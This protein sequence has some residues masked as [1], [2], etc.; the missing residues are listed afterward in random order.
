MASFRDLHAPDK[1]E[2]A[3]FASLHL[4]DGII[5]FCVKQY[6]LGKL[7]KLPSYLQGKHINDWDV[8]KVTNMSRLFEGLPK[9]NEPLFK[10]DVGLVTNMSSM[11]CDC[12]LFNQDLNAWGS[13]VGSVTNMKS[14]FQHCSH[15][16]MPL[17]KWDVSRV[18]TME[19][20]FDSC[21]LFNQ[22]LNAW[23]VGRVQNMISLFSGCATFNK[24]L[25]KWNVSNVKTMGTMFYYC[26]LFNQELNTWNV[27]NVQNMYRM[28]ERC[29]SF[30]QSLDQWIIGK[31]TI[32][33][34]M[35]RYAT[36]MNARTWIDRETD[37]NKKKML[38]DLNMEETRMNKKKFNKDLSGFVADAR[39]RPP[40]RAK[41]P[42]YPPLYYFGKD[43]DKVKAKFEKQVS[44]SL[45]GEEL[46]RNTIKK[47]PVRSSSPTTRKKKGRVLYNKSTTIGHELLMPLSPIRPSPTE[48]SIRYRKSVKQQ[49][50]RSGGR[51][52]RKKQK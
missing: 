48:G 2:S 23:D 40:Y 27:S 42:E 38:T 35:F 34:S 37:Y 17:D 11:F 20:M 31:S 25:D 6:Y 13:K 28:F 18:E 47:S 24:P 10:W 41:D 9:F 52:R 43:Y 39:I 5:R 29:D 21:N 30:N 12:S 50:Q 36:Q 22:D 3:A 7:S 49:Q 26:R 33:K 32:T 4:T 14:L 44:A 8:S 15:F 45:R 1:S 16:N 19:H 46:A 51:S